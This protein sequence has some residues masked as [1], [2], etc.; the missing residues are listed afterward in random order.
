MSLH[1]RLDTEALLQASRKVSSEIN[2]KKVIYEY[3]V[4]SR[5]Q[6]I[7]LLFTDC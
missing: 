1:I 7:E 5:Y 3:I 4:V 2:A 6:R